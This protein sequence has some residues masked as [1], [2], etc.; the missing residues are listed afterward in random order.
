MTN[1]IIRI[2]TADFNS[3]RG[4]QMGYPGGIQIHCFYHIPEPEAE[5]IS[6]NYCPQRRK[7]KIGSTKPNW[8]Y[9]S[10]GKQMRC[11]VN[12]LPYLKTSHIFG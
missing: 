9:A 4:Q 6:G 5:S 3:F 2:M 7:I 11:K 12:F 1:S 8:P 10:P